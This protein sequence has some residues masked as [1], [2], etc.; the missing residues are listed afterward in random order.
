MLSLKVLEQFR[1]DVGVDTQTKELIGGWAAL[2]SVRL[3]GMDF[4][5]RPKAATLLA[6]EIAIEVGLWEAPDPNKN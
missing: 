2:I 1:D 4:A 3:D 6:L 5:D